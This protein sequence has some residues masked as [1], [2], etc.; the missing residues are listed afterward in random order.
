M[1]SKPTLKKKLII[2]SYCITNN[3]KRVKLL[4]NNKN[5]HFSDH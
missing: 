1:L 5:E 4:S 3:K 2:K